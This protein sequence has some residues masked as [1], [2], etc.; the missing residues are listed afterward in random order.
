[1]RLV[2]TGVT[3]FVGSHFAERA[4]AAGHEVVGICNSSS[5][6]KAAIRSHL[7]ALGAK[8][9]DGNILKADSLAS[10]MQGGDC[11]CHFAAAFRESGVEDDYFLRMNVQGT[12]HVIEAAAAAGVNR[13]IYCSTGG[14][15]GQRVAGIIDEKMQAKPW[16]IYERSKVEAEQATRTLATK[17]GIEYVIL[18]PTSVYGPRDERLLKLF[19]SAAKGRFPLFGAGEGRRHMVY[20]TD[21]ADAFLDACAVPEAASQ[22]CIVAGP[23]ATSLKDMLKEL[24]AVVGRR[25]C[26]P[27]LPLA[28]MMLLSAVVE[29]VAGVIKIKPPLYRRRM[30]FYLN[31][32]AFSTNHAKSVLGWEPKVGLREGLALTLAAYRKDG[33]IS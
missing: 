14:I 12:T 22:E 33:L 28:P 29:D 6:E 32:A 2:V 11:V 23:Q 5:P 27:S 20:V 18:R 25:S 9:V 4:L 13:F 8:L 16:N 3:G 30:D 24:A 1:M 17:L 31:D 7:T 21:V 10:A 15:Y 26:G 19:K